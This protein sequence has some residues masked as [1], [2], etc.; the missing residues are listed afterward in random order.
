[1]A[2]IRFFFSHIAKMRAFYHECVARARVI[3][4]HLLTLKIL[5]FLVQKVRQS[6]D[7]V[8]YTFFPSYSLKK[9]GFGEPLITP[10]DC[11]NIKTSIPELSF[12]VRKI[13][14]HEFN[15]L[16]SGW[17]KVSHGVQ[18]AGLNGHFYGSRKNQWSYEQLE[19][20]RHINISN[21]H[22]SKKMFS[23]IRSD[24]EWIDWQLDFKSGYR[25]KNNQ[26]WRNIPYGHKQGVD[27]K[28][29][30]ELSRM[31]HLP[32]LA[33][34]Y[35]M[36]LKEAFS[37][38]SPEELMGEFESQIL[39]FISNNPPF[40]GVNWR[41]PMD[42][43]IRGANWALSMDIFRGFGAEFSKKFLSVLSSSLYDHGHFVF[44]HF[45][46]RIDFR[47][48]HYL[49]NIAGLGFIAFYLKA[50][51]KNI[52]LW[53]K[54]CLQEIKK[55]FNYQFH[56]CGTN[57][58]GSAAYHRLS[59]EMFVYSLILFGIHP[60]TADK[61]SVCRENLKKIGGMSF[62]LE[63]L[64]KPDGHIVQIGD[65]DSGRFFKLNP[66]LV[67]D[68]GIREDSLDVSHIKN[69]I[70]S[71][72]TGEFNEIEGE[73]ISRSLTRISRKLFTVAAEAVTGQT[74]FGRSYALSE[75]SYSIIM[76]EIEHSLNLPRRKQAPHDLSKA[77][78]S[79]KYFFTP[80][81]DY[82]EG[83][84]FF[85]FS[86]FGV[87]VYRNSRFFLSFRCGPVGQLG[88]GGHDHNDQLSIEL[89]YDNRNIV[90]DPGTFLYTPDPF[91]RNIYRSNSSHFCPQPE[92]LEM[93]NLNKGLFFIE[94]ASPGFLVSWDKDYI[95]G[96]SEGFGFPVY[97][98]IKL[99]RRIIIEDYFF[100]D[101][102]VL[103]LDLFKTRPYSPGYG[104]RDS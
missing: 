44:N 23:L 93:G 10:P 17:Q 15:L 42:I 98:L 46:K 72:L 101:V 83:L 26:W 81:E 74:P 63:A 57:F 45:E 13:M 33:Y 77:K 37:D 53:R 65:N 35:G 36:A 25:W 103:D 49:A 99:E 16:G 92:N 50:S 71:F 78:V 5:F 2:G 97:R 89:F 90:T 4:F 94:K 76:K 70:K 20:A 96:Y 3:P 7:H 102:N 43:A 18:C 87:A 38:Y 47:G 64:T 67:N 68:G 29:P 73:L 40:F 32:L 62:F 79:K 19:K 55:E 75:K 95:L 56:D 8:Y 104:L 41:C 100:K 51:D 69:I 66:V 12:L 54:T 61:Q 11:G 59:A 80:S 27:I 1:M 22:L 30:W 91:M 86:D 28:V 34:A 6:M 48:N 60:D 82:R 31:Q 39:D 84:Q 58:E 85:V 9:P 52:S 21:R 24:Y 14:N 88:R